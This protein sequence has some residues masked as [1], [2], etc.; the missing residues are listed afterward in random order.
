KASKVKGSNKNKETVAPD[1]KNLKVKPKDEEKFSADS[2]EAADNVKIN[3]NSGLSETLIAAITDDPD[4]KQGLFPGP[5]AH[6]STAKGGG[7]RKSHWQRKLAEILFA[8]HP[9]FSAA[10]AHSQKQ[11]SSKLQGIWGERVRNRISKMISITRGYIKEMGTTGEG[12]RS[13]EDID[14]SLDNAF[15]N[16]WKAIKS[17]CPWFWEMRDLIGERPNLVPA[18]IG[19][20][21]STVDMSILEDGGE[22]HEA[23]ASSTQPSER[24]GILYDSVAEDILDSDEDD[25]EPSGA[26]STFQESSDPPKAPT[27]ERPRLKDTKHKTSDSSINDTSD[28]NSSKRATKKTKLEEFAAAAQAEEVTRQRELELAKAKV[29]SAAE[30]EVAREKAKVDARQCKKEERLM[31]NQLRLEKMRMKHERDMARYCAMPTM[32]QAVGVPAIGGE[33]S[34]QELGVEFG[35]GGEE[36]GTVDNTFLR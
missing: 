14:M 19:N 12:I 3:W 16:K 26:R 2:K 27:P 13:A 21:S 22:S 15:V 20:S 11:K 9:E 28:K 30:V 10:Y 8:E 18:G 34:F 17:D 23:R 7:K 36:I 25:L 35:V 6:V 31:K 1:K 33:F 29:Q 24:G 32:P 4:I 5:G